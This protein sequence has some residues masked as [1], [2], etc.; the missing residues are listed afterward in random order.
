MFVSVLRS[1]MVA[2]TVLLDFTVSGNVIADV[3]K[4][5]NLKSRIANVLSEHFVGLKPLTESNIDGSLL[6]LYTGPRGSLITVRG[7]SEGLITVNIEY[8][9]RD[10]EEALLS[11]EVTYRAKADLEIPEKCFESALLRIPR[12]RNRYG[13]VARDFKMT[14][15]F[16]FHSLGSAPCSRLFFFSFCDNPLRNSE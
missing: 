5:S 16:K 8:Y 15:I 2:H 9:K 3:E 4:R 7:Y 6:V 13:R 12:M 10:D 14:T 1:A 11:F